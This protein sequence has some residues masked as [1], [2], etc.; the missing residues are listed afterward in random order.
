MKRQFSLWLLLV[1]LVTPLWAQ[2]ITHVVWDKTPIRLMLPLNK[3][4]M[5]RFPQAISIIDSELKDSE[6]EIV[7]L[8]DALYLKANASFISKRLVVQLMPDGEAIVLMLTAVEEVSETTPVEVVIEER[9][10]EASLPL[11]SAESANSG[12]NAVSLTRFAIQSLY[13]PSR[14]LVTP[15]GVARTPMQTH[16]NTTL[17]YGASVLARPLISWHGAELYVTAVE[18]KNQLNKSIV[19]D[20]HHLLGEWQTATFYPTNMLEG[21]GKRDTTTVFVTSSQPFG[22]ALAANQE[23]VR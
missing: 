15:A 23:F 21:R 17:V 13:S 7:K 6:A 19:I 16:R 22:E 18:L 3:E 14:L 2:E 1:L 12:I 4:R 5:I 20:P 11:T 10:A 8:Q 9:D